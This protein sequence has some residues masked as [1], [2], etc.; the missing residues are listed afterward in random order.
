[1]MLQMY[2]KHKAE[3]SEMEMQTLAQES[4]AKTRDTE[5]RKLRDIKKSLENEINDR[6]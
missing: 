4:I 6:K 3:V 1:M 2:T 5:F